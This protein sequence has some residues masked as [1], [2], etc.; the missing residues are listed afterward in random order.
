MKR[1]FLLLVLLIIPGTVIA[2]DTGEKPLPPITVMK[3][4]AITA[5]ETDTYEPND[6]PSQAYGPI[7]PTRYESYIWEPGDIDDY[8]YLISLG[9]TVQIGLSNIPAGCDYDL[10]IYHRQDDGYQLIASSA[11]F[12]DADELATFTATRATQYYIR[13]FRY[14]GYSNEHPYHLIA[15]FDP[16]HLIFLPDVQ[17]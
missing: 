6:S 10:Y 3:N 5:D 17:A 11:Q 16:A 13:V 8:Y 1:L 15:D 7:A 9:G 12:G 14:G 4:I 2:Q